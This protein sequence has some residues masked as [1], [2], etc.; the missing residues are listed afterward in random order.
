MASIR[1]QLKKWRS[2]LPPCIVWPPS[3]D[4]PTLILPRFVQ[5][6]HLN[7]TYH[8]VIVLL[9]LYNLHLIQLLRPYVIQIAGQHAL[10][11]VVQDS[12]KECVA[13]AAEIVDLCRYMRDYHGM[14]AS[15]LSLQQ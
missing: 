3:L 13:A 2:T 5:K 6:A 4:S 8:S 1:T 15:P 12:M 9:A 10:G 7:V 14:P 11:R